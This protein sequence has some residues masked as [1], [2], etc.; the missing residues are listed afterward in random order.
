M[1]RNKGIFHF[2]VIILVLFLGL[3]LCIKNANNLREMKYFLEKIKSKKYFKFFISV[4]NPLKNMIIQ[5]LLDFSKYNCRSPVDK[6]VNKFKFCL[7][8]IFNHIWN[9]CNQSW[10]T[11]IWTCIFICEKNNFF[12][13]S[14][15]ITLH[16]LSF[17]LQT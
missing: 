11:N 16:P 1:F 5:Q 15:L 6:I 9:G 7:K 17:P 4:L 8:I 3:F 14:L 2:Y 10:A 12:L 13:V